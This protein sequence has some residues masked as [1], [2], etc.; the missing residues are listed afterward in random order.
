[1]ADT[2]TTTS[3]LTIKFPLT[4]DG[5][6]SSRSI[7]LP[8]PVVNSVTLATFKENFLTALEGITGYQ[9]IFQPT[10]WRDDDDQ[11]NAW[12][13]NTSKNIEFEL[14]QTTRTILE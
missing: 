6:E 12:Q 13:L 10:N 3:Y 5:E 7:S 1:M 8:N 11:D 14:V 9:W 4:R 2:I